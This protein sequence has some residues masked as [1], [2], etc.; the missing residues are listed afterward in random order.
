MKVILWCIMM[1]LL[2]K[3]AFSTVLIHWFPVSHETRTQKQR[4]LEPA[5][6]Q[7]RVQP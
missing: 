7:E 1:G 6:A 2:I 5:V 4:V 3:L